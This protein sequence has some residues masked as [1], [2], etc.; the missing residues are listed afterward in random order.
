MI[1]RFS[2]INHAAIVLATVLAASNLPVYAQSSSDTQSTS[3]LKSNT[4]WQDNGL[5]EIIVTANKREESIDKVGLTIQALGGD[6]IRQQQINSPLD[7]AAAVPGL[8][9]SQT[10]ANTPVYTL[11]GIGFYDTSFAAF[12]AVTVYMDQAPLPLPVETTNSLF[13]LERVEVLK[14]PQGTVFGNNATG[15]A[16]NYIAAK[17]TEEDHAGLTV[18]YGRFQTFEADGFASGPVTPDFLVRLAVHAVDGDGWQISATRPTNTNGAPKT[19]AAR[20]LTD[21][22]PA[23][24]LRVQ[25]NINGW[26]DHTQP[27]QAQFVAFVPSFT[28][29]IPNPLPKPF[30]PN[31]SDDPRIA[32]WVPQY[33]PYEDNGLGQGT[34]RVDYDLTPHILFTSISS[35]TSYR[36]HESPD[37]DGTAPQ[38][39]DNILDEGK[40]ENI[41][42]ELRL[43]NNVDSV[44]RWLV[45][46]NFEHDLIDENEIIDYADGTA[47]YT[48]S[49]P[50]QLDLLGITP[51]HWSFSAGDSQQ[52]QATYAGFA[53][54]E[55]TVSQVTFKAGA[56]FT[57]NRRDSANCSYTP[58]QDGNPSP[59]LSFFSELASALS[60]QTVHLTNGQCITLGSNDLPHEVYGRL[61][62][63]NVAWRLGI[64][65]HA[66]DTMLL[67]ANAAKGYKAGSFPNGTAATDLGFSPVRQESVLT[68]EAGVKSQLLEHRLDINAA[69]FYSDYK[70]KQIKSKLLDPVFGYLLA[71]VN[72]P[73]SEIAGGEFK[74][75]AHPFRGLTV[76]LSGVVLETKLLNTLGP[77]GNYL[78]S[79]ANNQANF[80]G[81]P[82]PYAPRWTLTANVN[83]TFPITDDVATFIGAQAL[84]RTRTTSSIGNEPLEEIP[85]YSTVDLQM[86]VSWKKDRY[87]AMLWGKNITNELVVTNRNFSFDGVAQYVGMPVTYGITLSGSF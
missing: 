80:A 48:P 7:L 32:D 73:K 62:E 20:F 70:D 1:V 37:G 4:T 24:G 17:P 30:I 75:A 40:I 60:G 36:Q 34:V 67:Y 43:A 5:E 29:Y 8:S 87:R 28:N 61:D 58:I 14:G 38:R 18:G 21:W 74:V 44:F 55:Y 45:G 13:D 83:Y 33:P 72:V 41:F 2:G 82:I 11:R 81:N 15:G 12:P 19:L 76:G 54:G 65:W 22:K 6:E 68:Y 16:I 71:L 78:I 39:N 84:H 64:D 23:D 47:H 26:L 69:A 79:N 35:Y 42:Q 51:G 77:D 59:N 86:G 31:A 9:Y 52:T 63:N 85:G 53:S 49:L 10:E 66:S 25:T 27:T 3:D 50:A 57:E 46:G 56:R